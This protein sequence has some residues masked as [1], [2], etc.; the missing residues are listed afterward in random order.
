MTS[1]SL[2]FAAIF[3]YF[4]IVSCRVVEFTSNFFISI[5]FPFIIQNAQKYDFFS[6]SFYFFLFALNF[7]LFGTFFIVGSAGLAVRAV[8]VF[9]LCVTYNDICC[10]VLCIVFQQWAENKTTQERQREEENKKKLDVENFYVKVSTLWFTYRIRCVFLEN[11][12]PFLSFH[13]VRERTKQRAKE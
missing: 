6:F 11:A 5:S 3:F 7:I 9:V 8:F 10:I 4:S 1:L 12:V 13:I 2:R